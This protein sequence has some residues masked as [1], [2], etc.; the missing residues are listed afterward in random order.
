MV[1][2]LLSL[3][4]A[5][6]PIRIDQRAIEVAAETIFAS[7]AA[8]FDR[9]RP[10]YGN[11]GIAG[12]QSCVPLSWYAQPHGWRER[13]DLFVTH[14]LELLECAIA[15]C[16][17]Q[18]RL[19]PAAIDGVV[20]VSSTGMTAPSLDARLME[21]I[22]FRRDLQ[23]LP[24]FGL[25]C[26]GGV[27]GLARAAALARAHPGERW[28]LLV[29]ELCGL[30]FRQD[31]QSNGNIVAT[32][33]F[34]DGAAAALLCSEGDGPL[35]RAGGEYTWPGTLD[36]MGWDIED[37]GFGVIFGREIPALVRRDFRE[38]AER[39]LAGSG[40]LLSDID[41]FVLHPGGAKV[42]DALRDAL[43]VPAAALSVARDVLRE[44]GN[45]SAATILFVL[46]RSLKASPAG[47]TLLAALGP[48]FSAG[49]GI[50]EA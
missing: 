20:V 6:P 42:I 8:D 47:T 50:L 27:I 37:D 17:A 31:D 19:T 49:F 2:R 29:V 25:G 43:G 5:V 44:F 21:R 46:Q 36:V 24:V 28:L 35:F 48:G 41:R 33:L 3:A 9:L 14:G 39:F 45:M 16:L 12:R 4:T 30:T 11:S 7:R 23:R 38:A 13:H 34:G 18:V 40:L 26:A 22:A 10:I 32:A 1:P 15:E